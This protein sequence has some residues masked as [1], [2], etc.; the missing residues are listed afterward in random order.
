MRLMNMH[1]GGAS[2][3]GRWG[4]GEGREK[5][6][7]AQVLLHMHR[8]EKGGERAWASAQLALPIS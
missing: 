4:R 5:K 7:T 8:G 6:E 2:K 3:K 1:G